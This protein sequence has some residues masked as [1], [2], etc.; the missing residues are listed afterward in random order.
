[1]NEN[2]KYA[3]IEL[4]SRLISSRFLSEIACAG[5][6]HISESNKK[7]AN[8]R[9]RG[10]SESLLKWKFLLARWTRVDGGRSA[11]SRDFSV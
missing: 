1:M 7:N 2:N 6:L 11:T 4:D 8:E 3:I 9:E 10:R 5:I